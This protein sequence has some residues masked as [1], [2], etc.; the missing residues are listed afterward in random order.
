MRALI[1]LLLATPAQAWDFTPTPVCTILNDT[2]DLSIRVTYDPSRPQP[3]AITLTRPDPWPA[4][5]TFGLRFDGPAP[6]TI[7]TAR[8]RLSADGRTLSVTDTGFGNVLDG[9]ARNATATAVAGATEIP[10]DLAGARPAV[11]AFRACGIEPSA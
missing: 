4:S 10:F 6:L 7:G 1:A 11:E 8:H 5:D 9:L 3:Y 2:P